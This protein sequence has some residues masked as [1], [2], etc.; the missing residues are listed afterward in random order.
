VEKVTGSA[1]LVVYN[2]RQDRSIRSEH[3]RL[4]KILRA[5]FE[6]MPQV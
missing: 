1:D 6:A 2:P 3:L 5:A 4:N